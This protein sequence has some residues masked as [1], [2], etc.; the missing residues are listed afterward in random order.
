MP[1]NLPP[2]YITLILLIIWTGALIAFGLIHSDVYGM[3]EGAAKNLILIWSVVDQI[4]SPVGTY[5]SPDFRAFL[6]IP[7]GLYW[8]GS[9][10]AAKVFTAIIMFFAGVLLFQLH[11]KKNYEAASISTA[12]L[13]LSPIVITQ[14]DAVGSGAYLLLCFGLSHVVDQRYRDSGNHLGGSYFIQILILAL[15]VSLHP[16]GLA[17]PI[18]IIWSWWNE[19]ND[20]VA[21][22]SVLISTIV[23]TILISAFRLGWPD[24]QSWFTNPIQVFSDAAVNGLSGLGGKAHIGI[25]LFLLSLLSIILFKDRE[26]ILST[27]TGRSLTIAVLIGLLSADASWA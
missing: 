10:F 9:L 19:K 24:I 7:V 11:S 15:A 14:I 16:M 6:F 21:R 2:R 26:N 4:A 22:K 1:F 17:Y 12:L 25:G 23:T 5:G 20:L 13:L 27:L 3:E 8:P 18:A